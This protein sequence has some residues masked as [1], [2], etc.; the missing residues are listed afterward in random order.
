MRLVLRN[1][2]GGALRS[3]GDNGMPISTH[4][5]SC[6]GTYYSFYYHTIMV[7][8]SDPFGGVPPNMTGTDSMGRDFI[9]LTIYDDDGTI[10]SCVGRNSDG[11]Y[12]SAAIN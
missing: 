11:V 6:N 9:A 12:W 5:V 7:V 10:I 1:P 4:G 2:H 3:L 8:P